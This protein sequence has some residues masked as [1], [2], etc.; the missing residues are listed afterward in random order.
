ML[1]V[2]AEVGEPIAK[3]P[4]DVDDQEAIGD[5]FPKFNERISKGL[6]PAAIIGD[7]ERALR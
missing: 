4:E 2:G 1:D 3:A 6:H 7:G 5:G